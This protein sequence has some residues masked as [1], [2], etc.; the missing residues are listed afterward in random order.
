MIRRPSSDLAVSWTPNTGVLNYACVNKSAVNDAIYNTYNIY[1]ARD[2]FGH[3][4]FEIPLDAT[5]NSVKIVVR[6][7]IDEVADTPFLL[8]GA[9]FAGGWID[10]YLTGDP[11]T[12]TDSFANYELVWNTNPDV[13]GAWTPAQVNALTRIGYEDADE[14]EYNELVTMLYIEADYTPAG[15]DPT[16]PMPTF[17]PGT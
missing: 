11:F 2:T 3:A 8:V 1:E 6:A 13:G 10:N 16:Y 7:M 12:L 4:A 17:K 15:G 14:G 9:L 5:V